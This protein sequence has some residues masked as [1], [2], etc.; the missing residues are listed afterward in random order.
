MTVSASVV[1]ALPRALGCLLAL[2]LGLA[3]SG[4]ADMSDNMSAAFA[5]PAQYELYDCKQLETARKGLAERAAQLQ[6]LMAKAETGTGGAVVSELAYRN[7]Y[8]AVR[9]QMKF[10]DDAWRRNKCREGAPSSVP[11]P[12]TRPDF[13]PAPPSRSGSAVY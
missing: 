11:P 6:G 8:V 1:P 13:K 5:D 12:P 3:L 9:G 4:C 10:A 2:A 7:D